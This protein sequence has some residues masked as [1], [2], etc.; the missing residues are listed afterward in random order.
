LEFWRVSG[1]C[2][3]SIGMG[4]WGRLLVEEVVVVSMC[5]VSAGTDLIVPFAAFEDGPWEGLL[6]MFRFAP[7]FRV[8]MAFEEMGE[9]G[10]Q[11]RACMILWLMPNAGS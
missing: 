11:V 3:L 6:W 5:K 8:F 2:E 9:R 4:N 7:P 10:R 1:G